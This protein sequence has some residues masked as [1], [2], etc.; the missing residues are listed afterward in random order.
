MRRLPVSK[1]EERLIEI[2]ERFNKIRADKTGRACDE[3]SARF[4]SKRLHYVRGQGLRTEF[5][6]TLMKLT[7]G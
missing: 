6:H 7:A 4:R 5:I 3:P 2:Q 1:T